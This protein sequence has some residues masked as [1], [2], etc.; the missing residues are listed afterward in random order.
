MLGGKRD[1][2]YDS[3]GSISKYFDGINRTKTTIVAKYPHIYSDNPNHCF[4]PSNASLWD[5][6]LLCD[7]S[8]IIRRIMFTNI[9]ASYYNSFHGAVMYVAAIQ[10]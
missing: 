5:N 10:N 8:L 7:N 6:N 1:I 2:I 3:D 4:T 9:Y